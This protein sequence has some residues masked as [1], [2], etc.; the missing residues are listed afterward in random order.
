MSRPSSPTRDSSSRAQRGTGSTRSSSPRVVVAAAGSE[1]DEAG[2]LDVIDAWDAI[3]PSLDAAIQ[4]RGREVAE[5]IERRLAERMQE[6]A[7]RV[8]KVLS[9]LADRI[10]E[11]LAS[12]E[13]EGIQLTL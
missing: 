10:R 12:V 8:R 11:R 4:Q 2:A 1:A 6:D 9:E 13:R 7:E 5:S 3:E